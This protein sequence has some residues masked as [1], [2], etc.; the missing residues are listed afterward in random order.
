M[1]F[2]SISKTYWGLGLIAFICIKL[3]VIFF[4]PC[5]RLLYFSNM[6]AAESEKFFIY[7]GPEK[8]ATYPKR[9]IYI[10]GKYKISE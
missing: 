3:C 7:T 8:G 1:L 9:V 2:H 6:A 10:E 4:I 5:C